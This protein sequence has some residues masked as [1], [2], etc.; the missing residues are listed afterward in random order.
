[1]T[2]RVFVSTVHKAK[3]LEFDNVVIYDVT[4]GNYPGFFTR[5][6]PGRMEEE[7]RRFYVAISRARRRL[8]LAWSATKIN[9]YGRVFSTHLSQFTLPIQRFFLMRRA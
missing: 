4:D 7:R 3:G 2:E 8:F 9:Q 6:H 5:Q 1:M